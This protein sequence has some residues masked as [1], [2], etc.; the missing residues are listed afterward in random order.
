MNAVSAELISGTEGV[1]AGTA[2]GAAAAGSGCAGAAGSSAKD[3][4]GP[5]RRLSPPSNPAATTVLRLFPMLITDVS[6]AA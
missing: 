6:A 3:H 4:E 1:A 5:V 2:A